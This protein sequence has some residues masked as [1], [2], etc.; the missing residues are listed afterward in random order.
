LTHFLNLIYYNLCGLHY[1]IGLKYDQPTI[2][3]II[4]GYMDTE[5]VWALLGI[6]FSKVTGEGGSGGP[7]GFR[8]RYLAYLYYNGFFDTAGSD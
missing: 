5:K 6:P 8:L 7:G 1:H 4:T 2:I 3:Q